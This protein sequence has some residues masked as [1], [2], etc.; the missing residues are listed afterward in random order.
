MP[1]KSISMR[2]EPLVHGRWVEYCP[3]EKALRAQGWPPFFMEPRRGRI[4]KW[5]RTRVYVVFACD[6]NWDRYA[7]YLACPVSPKFLSFIDPPASPNSHAQD[8]RNP[9]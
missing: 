6:G 5:T 3:S 9:F 8:S 4:K 7:D 2:P 1:K